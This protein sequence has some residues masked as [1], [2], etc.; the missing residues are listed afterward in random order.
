MNEFWILFLGSYI[1][2]IKKYSQYKTRGTNPVNKI[3]GWYLLLGNP[4]EDFMR[5][6]KD[7]K[8]LEV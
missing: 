1:E 6:E 3:A 8:S 7:R 4:G 2:I 5:L